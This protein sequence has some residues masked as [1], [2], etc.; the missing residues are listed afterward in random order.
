MSNISGS[1]S[2]IT[3]MPFLLLATITYL[4]T[5]NMIRFSRVRQMQRTFGYQDRAS[6][7]NMTLEDAQ[8]IQNYLYKLEFPWL[9][10][11]SLEFALFRTYGIPSVSKLLVQTTQLSDPKSASKRVEDTKI[12]VIQFMTQA[13]TADLA[14]GAIARMN[15]IHSL[16]QKSGRISND[17]MLYTLSLFALEPIR[18]IARYEWRELNDMEKCSIG[19]FW[20]AMGDAMRIDFQELTSVETELRDGLD[21]LTK[22]EAWSISY[23]EKYMVADINNK[24]TADQTSNVLL[25]KVP[26]RMRGLGVQAISSLMDR[27]LRKAMM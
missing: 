21:W 4:C 23:E 10:Q 7:A 22:L 13:P 26:N 1:L 16:Y 14:M 12:L 8:K 27:R 19:V 15:Y 6:L 18:W 2:Q 25:W 5:A 3:G 17:D 11:K 24:I 20:K 9:M